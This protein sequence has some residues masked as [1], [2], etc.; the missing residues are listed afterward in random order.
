MI[1]RLLFSAPIRA[2]AS[3]GMWLRGKQVAI[4]FGEAGLSDVGAK[5]STG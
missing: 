4:I 5:S 3:L 1:R 2:L